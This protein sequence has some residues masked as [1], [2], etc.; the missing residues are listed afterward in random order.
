MVDT[1]RYREEIVEYRKWL[2]RVR[3]QACRRFLS[4]LSAE[5]ARTVEGAIA[6]AVGW[7]WLASR[8][9][10][11]LAESES[12][13]GVDFCISS[14]EGTCYVEIT[15]LTQSKISRKTNLYNELGKG[16][17]FYSTASRIIKS[18]VTK[19]V[20]QNRQYDNSYLIFV[21]GLHFEFT[22]LLTSTGHLSELLLGREVLYGSVDLGD[23]VHDETIKSVATMDHT[24]FCESGSIRPARQSVSGVLVGGFGAVRESCTV[25][26]LLNQFA[27]RPFNQAILPDTCFGRIEPWPI[28]SG[29]EV[30]WERADGSVCT[31]EAELQRSRLCAERRL[32]LQ[33]LGGFL[34]Q[35]RRETCT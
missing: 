19:K 17:K 34:D 15:A 29:S 9:E 2:E 24:L 26:G 22:A 14:T 11:Q 13:G 21:I 18:A 20:S 1:E 3:P 10:V 27:V 33:G 30:I 32:R 16:A 35:L 8:C 4:K 6:E 12:S 25:K 23:A 5:D 31:D 28:A 7:C